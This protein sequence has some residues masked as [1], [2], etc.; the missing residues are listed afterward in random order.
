VHHNTLQLT[1]RGQM[2]S[3]PVP[4]ELLLAADVDLETGSTRVRELR[5]LMPALK[6]PHG[7]AAAALLQPGTALPAR[8][9]GGVRAEFPKIAARLG[10]DGLEVAD[11]YVERLLEG[12]AFLAARVQLKQD[13][14]FPR[15]SH[16]L[17]ELV[18]PNYLESDCRRCWW[19]RCSPCWADANLLRG[20]EVPR[21]TALKS[22]AS[23][24][25]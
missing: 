16:R 8:D 14:E 23:S 25:R 3:Q 1:I 6:Q 19:R 12:C 4:L 18:Y 7:P 21:D 22:G 15:L 17:L 10:M 24:T 5:G 13:A 9:G 11:P 20:M 2:W